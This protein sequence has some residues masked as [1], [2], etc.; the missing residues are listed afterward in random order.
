[1]TGWWPTITSDGGSNLRRALAGKV[2]KESRSREGGIADWVYCAAHL[3][4][5]WVTAAL[6]KLEAFRAPT[7]PSAK[8]MC[9][10]IDR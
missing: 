4:H 1:M 3:L 10:A 5:L 2:E 9:Q 7:T 6:K 8:F